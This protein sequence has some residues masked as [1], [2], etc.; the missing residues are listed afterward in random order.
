MSNNS[1]PG[2]EDLFHLI[3]S[4]T[5]KMIGW[6]EALTY[7]NGKTPRFNDSAD[8]IA[9]SLYEIHDYADR[10]KI[11]RPKTIALKESG[12]RKFKNSRYECIVD[13]GIPSP[14]HQP[15]HSH[16]DIFSFE[17][18]VD[19]LPVIVDT[20]TSTYEEFERRHTERSTRSHNTVQIGSY[21]QAEIWSYFRI[22]RRPKVYN[23]E[24]TS[25]FISC[26]HDG[27]KNGKYQHKRSFRF[28]SNDIKIFDEIS[29][30]PMIPAYA[31]LHFHPDQ[32]VKLM[33]P[34][35]S[36]GDNV[37]ITVDGASNIRLEE[38]QYAH[39][40]NKLQ[41]AVCAVITFYSEIVT[42]VVIK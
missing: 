33:G 10:L 30:K 13:Y 11:P 23:F 38:Y 22:G 36:A 3:K 21:E 26:S 17:L 20:G 35:I 32:N 15:G 7:T 12:Y 19:H 34:F 4:K 24:D 8:D 1:Y 18:Y 29:P 2:S 5:I 6:I 31:Y 42:T 25:D 27:F 39:G 28:R 14:A 37:Q 40:F 41:T 16:C 9:P